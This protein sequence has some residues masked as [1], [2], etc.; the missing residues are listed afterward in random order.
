MARKLPY[1]LE[2]IDTS[3]RPRRFLEAFAAILEHSNY[4]MALDTFADEPFAH[5]L[6]DGRKQVG[7]DV[8]LGVV[9]DLA[10]GSEGGEHPEHLVATGVG[11]PGV[12]LAV[13]V[14]T[15][16]AFA[17]AIV[18][19]LHHFAAT[20]EGGEIKAPARD[21]FPALQDHRFQSL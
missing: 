13:G 10:R 2:D 7:A 11:H 14:R 20:Q 8:G 17:E 15:C 9:E 18:R 19:I 12:E 4:G 6:D 5:A 1:Y 3:D 21:V 16:P